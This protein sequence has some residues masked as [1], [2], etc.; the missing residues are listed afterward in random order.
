MKEV[1]IAIIGVGSV[2]STIAY[3]LILK[4]I[5]CRIVLVD[6]DSKRCAGEQLDLSDV[7]AFSD[8]PSIVQGTYEDAK[9]ADIVIVAAGKNQKPGQTRLALLEANKAVFASILY[10]LKGINPQALLIV[11]A[12]PLDVLTY[13]AHKTF[14]LPHRQMFGM[15]TLLDSLRLKLA[16][17]NT[18][19]IAPDAVH[20][21][22]VGEHGDSQVVAWSATTVAGVPVEQC[23]LEQSKKEIFA[24][25]AKNQ[26][27]EIIQL[28]G[29][30]YYG[31]ATC[32]AFVCKAIIFDTKC[33]LP[34]SWYHEKYQVCFSLPVVLGAGGIERVIDLDYTREEREQLEKSAAVLKEYIKL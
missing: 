29:A 4:N 26:A 9:K 20:A 31:I 34:L 7:L 28:K 16:I 19:H 14:T 17:S 1:T 25:K 3:A 13:M 22:V 23:G 18:L 32:V 21:T 15:G 24:Q 6:I 8:V 5:P 30:T 2:G 10:S 12:N 27:Y 11:V 33:I